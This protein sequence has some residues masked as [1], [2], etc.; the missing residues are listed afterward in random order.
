MIKEKEITQEEYKNLVTEIREK[1][2]TWGEQ[3]REAGW[4]F[5]I[6]DNDYLYFY[7]YS[8]PTPCLYRNRGEDVGKRALNPITGNKIIR[9]PVPKGYKTDKKDD[10]AIIHHLTA[11]GCPKLIPFQTEVECVRQTTNNKYYHCFHLVGDCPGKE[12]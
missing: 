4:D 7:N 1:A 2:K 5:G 11:S 6:W 10:I 9:K 12:A 8:A 3:A